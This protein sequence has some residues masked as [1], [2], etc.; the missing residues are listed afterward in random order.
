MRGSKMK[1]L[2]LLFTLLAV[3]ANSCNKR[4]FDSNKWKNDKEAQYYMLDDIVENKILIGKSKEEIIQLLDT[5][6]DK[7]F[8]KEED[9]WGY[10]I[11]IPG[12][13]PVTKTPVIWLLVDFKYNKVVKAYI[14]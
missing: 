8:K 13:V 2:Q 7:G 5:V 9:T 4:T 11:G 10:V 14:R 1:Y 6:D 3:F 12:P